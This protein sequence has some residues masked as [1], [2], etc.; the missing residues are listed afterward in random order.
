MPEYQFFL[1]Q[2]E[3]YSVPLTIHLPDFSIE[4]VEA[5]MR[6]LY[7]GATKLKQQDFPKLHHLHQ[8]F[9][10]REAGGANFPSIYGAESSVEKE[11][12]VGENPSPHQE[13]SQAGQG[14]NEV[15]DDLADNDENG[16]ENN[17][18]DLGDE[19]E[20]KEDEDS[21]SSDNNVPQDSEPE[22]GRQED[23]ME[24]DDQ[25]VFSP[26]PSPAPGHHDVI[27]NIT[28]LLGD[29]SPDSEFEISSQTG[30]DIPQPPGDDEAGTED[31]MEEDFL[32]ELK[33]TVPTSPEKKT[34]KP[35]PVKI[36]LKKRKF[37][38]A[39]A[40]ENKEQKAESSRRCVTRSMSGDSVEPGLP[41]GLDSPIEKEGRKDEVTKKRRRKS[42]SA[43]SLQVDASEDEVM[44]IFIKTV[45]GKWSTEMIKPSN[46]IWELKLK[47]QIKEG[48]PP[49]EQRFSYDG[50]KLK[51]WCTLAD[52]NIQAY[53]TLRMDQALDMFIKTNVEELKCPLKNCE[54][55]IRSDE[56]YDK[57]YLFLRHVIQKH[58]T[59]SPCNLYDNSLIRDPKD[60]RRYRCL[61]CDRSNESSTSIFSHMAFSHEDLFKRIRDKLTG[62]EWLGKKSKKILVQ[63][64]QF[65]NSNW[66]CWADAEDGESKLKEVVES[67]RKA[68]LFQ[69]TAVGKPSDL[70]G[71]SKAVARKRSK[72]PI[73]ELFDVDYPKSDRSPGL[74][75]KAKVSENK[76]SAVRDHENN[77]EPRQ[78]KE[79]ESE[80]PKTK[81]SEVESSQG[82]SE[83][84][85]DVVDLSSFTITCKHCEFLYIDDV[86]LRKHLLGTHNTM[87]HSIPLLEAGEKH[88]E[89]KLNCIKSYKTKE[90]MQLAE[91]LFRAHDN[92]TVELIADEKSWKKLLS[93]KN[94]CYMTNKKDMYVREPQLPS[95][96]FNTFSAKSQ[97][98]PIP[99]KEEDPDIIVDEV[100]LRQKVRKITREKVEDFVCKVC[101]LDFQ[102]DG[103]AVAKHVFLSHL[104]HIPDEVWNSLYVNE[105]GQFVCG[106]CPCHIPRSFLRELRA[107]LHVYNQH[108][109]ELK[110]AMDK[111]KVDWRN[112]LDFIRFN[113]PEDEPLE[114]EEECE[115]ED[116]IIL[117]DSPLNQAAQQETETDVGEDQ[118][119]EKVVQEIHKP[120]KDQVETEYPE[121]NGGEIQET[122]KDEGEAQVSENGEEEIQEIHEPEKDQV[123]IDDPEKNEGQI[124]E[125]E[126]DAG[127]IQE[128]KNQD[129]I[130]E[131]EK[132]ERDIQELIK[133]EDENQEPEREEGEIWDDKDEGEIQEPRK[134][135]EENQETEKDEDETQETERDE[136]E[137]QEHRKVQ[138]ETQEPER[139]QNEALATVTPP[140][141]LLHCSYL[142][143]CQHFSQNS[144]LLQHYL[145]QHPAS[146]WTVAVLKV[147]KKSVPGDEASQE[148]VVRMRC[149]ICGASFL[150]EV[151]YYEHCSLHQDPGERS[152]CS[153]CLLFLSKAEVEAHSRPGQ[154]PHYQEKERI[155]SLA[156][157]LQGGLACTNLR[158][159]CREK[160]PDKIS[161]HSHAKT[162]SRRPSRSFQCSV[163]GC[164]RKFYYGEDLEKHIKKHAENIRNIEN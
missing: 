160:L 91:H 89:C 35:K 49:E 69:A 57:I 129:E 119:T 9:C 61:Y 138:D 52:Y 148:A 122:E 68:Q 56:K 150:E 55:V 47:I 20:E 103:E 13:Q 14:Q 10:I 62:P 163:R 108:K 147:L 26:T 40:C 81:T 84:E 83:G 126:K 38:A 48:I 50:K 137:I 123:E 151:L 24:E 3:H 66:D 19:N 29:D 115:D 54:S 142:G 130:H 120:E 90:K 113:I 114:E 105:A 42:S 7:R 25:A 157:Q 100:F 116:E 92:I 44:E 37:D 162:C 36:K 156:S 46:T 99:Q 131:P 65:L 33:T 41:L 146:P 73:K 32:E 5:F 95:A 154:C 96:F 8:T 110:K 107:K 140:S 144:E 133:V 127:E 135:Q 22:E 16:S 98:I 78:S 11:E 63:I 161:L 158:A 45:T 53:S 31:Q 59:G 153:H 121:K 64:N 97:A 67:H 18:E 51:D 72:D 104:Q 27:D 15:Q 145:S 88:Y 75:K 77:P 159:G 58:L 155:Q 141:P 74:V 164:Y 86:T 17:Q 71:N 2:P 124:Q 106:T 117:A 30:T 118:E 128:L 112:L 23:R 93:Y 6:S 82:S 152:Q 143:C 43:P 80:F 39:F 94:F 4:V 149:E 70:I 102:N 109:R 139:D 125:T 134:D 101:D 136:E 28:D 76:R 60:K 132:N 87:F 12:E 21:E 34:R 85:D 1:F 79:K 111:N